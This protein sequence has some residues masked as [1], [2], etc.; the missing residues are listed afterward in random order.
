MNRKIKFRAWHNEAGYMVTSDRGVY[1]AL[2]HGLNVSIG[3]GFSDINTSA[4]PLKYTLMQYTGLKDNNGKE[5]YEGDIFKIGAEKE[6]FEVRFEHG[7]FMAFC[8]GRQAGLVGELQM[9]FINVIGNI[10][11][12]PELL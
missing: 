8:D 2:Q 9:C 4:K 1:T 12:N 5:I 10:F 3:S 7:C 11:E 6:I